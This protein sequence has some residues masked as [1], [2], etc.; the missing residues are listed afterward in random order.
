MRYLLTLAALV[1]IGCGAASELD[2]D[3]DDTP[4]DWCSGANGNM[5]RIITDPE[6]TPVNI[7]PQG[8]PAVA[9]IIPRNGYWSGNNNLG[10]EVPFELTDDRKLSVLKMPEWGPPTVWT[11][12]LGIEG[13]PIDEDNETAIITGE[14]L[15]GVGGTTQTM[16]VDWVN[17]TQFQVVAN[18]IEI[19]ALTP[20][21][22]DP[23]PD[24][25]LRAQIGRGGC[26]NPMAQKTIQLQQLDGSPDF[27]SSTGA[28]F[29]PS[30]G[31][32]LGGLVIPPYTKRLNIVP[33]YSD[34][35]RA[36]L[37]AAFYS[38]DFYAL[39]SRNN[40]LPSAAAL[41]AG[42]VI[43]GTELQGGLF[44]PMVTGS[45][46]VAMVNDSATSFFVFV[47]AELF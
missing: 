30:G 12:S 41:G 2:Y 7:P 47:I 3:P 37:T 36:S 38:D 15:F 8:V 27:E 23:T 21:F 31:G 6:N 35:S 4:V 42:G 22:G 9:S 26:S 29:L 10:A 32:E 44:L 17:G 33:R 11:I 40:V 5:S 20:A 45:R 43:R 28:F 24:I 25:R 1:L 16:L 46:F 13:I 14:I 39:T 19:R 34:G 18:A